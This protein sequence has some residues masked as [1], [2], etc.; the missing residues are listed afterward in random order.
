MSNSNRN[1]EIRSNKISDTSRKGA[2]RHNSDTIDPGKL[3]ELKNATRP[4]QRVQERKTA[5]KT[6]SSEAN[7]FSPNTVGY[8]DP[9]EFERAYSKEIDDLNQYNDRDTANNH[10]AA[11]L[12]GKGTG[13][14]NSNKFGKWLIAAVTVII[15]AALVWFYTQNDE[16]RNAL[17]DSLLGNTTNSAESEVT[18]INDDGS[19]I[20]QANASGTVGSSNSGYYDEH[21]NFV[22]ND[23]I[24]DGDGMAF[25]A[26]KLAARLSKDSAS[27]N[28]I[29]I[30]GEYDGR[31]A[32]FLE[33]NAEPLE[34]YDTYISDLPEADRNYIQ[35]GIR[36]TSLSELATYLED[37]TS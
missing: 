22:T 37:L 7:R 26:D 35:K 9:E 14:A 33:D 13:L 12:Q 30:I 8:I 25:D 4:S 21:G 36:T 27:E 3:R 6:I 28:R 10:R 23:T 15:I 11:T 32:I 20:E 18:H 19:S 1:T 5:G 31:L 24:H 29:F 2:G 17:E 34:I 16:S